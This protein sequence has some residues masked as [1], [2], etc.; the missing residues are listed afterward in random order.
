MNEINDIKI[1][2]LANPRLTETQQAAL[3]F[4][5]TLELEFAEA[6]ILGKARQLTGLSDFGADD[7]RERL[8]VLLQ[9]W[10]NDAGLTGL[11]RL[12]L[13][14]KLVQHA[15]SRLLIE[16]TLKRHPEILDIEIKAPIIVAG[17]PRSG[18]TH[19][20][21][22][23]AA[24][25][26]LRSL[27]LWEAYEPLPRPGESLLPHGRDPRWQRCEDSWQ[28]MQA[29]SP[30]L[31]AMHPMNPDHIHE[32]LELMGPNFA[33]YNYEWLTPSPQWRDHYFSHDQTPHYQYMKNVLKILQWRAGPQRWVLK[34]PQHMEQLTVLHKLF[35][36]ATIAITHRDPVAV[37]QS[38]ITM[39]GYGQRMNRKRVDLPGLLEY[40]SD[41][42][43]HLLRA[44]VR[45]RDTLPTAQA[46]DVP[47]K[48]FM[49]DDIAVVEQIYQRAGMPFEERARGELNAFMQAHPRGK[50]GR[51]VYDLEGDFGISPTT[52]R[53]RFEFYFER[54]PSAG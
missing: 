46:I 23:M 20:L 25:S 18:T 24:D 48:T 6:D 31:A 22:L 33:S 4:C 45:D 53:E 14:N 42:I 21:N 51:I 7:F 11:G 38:A 30:Y 1:T 9:E 47:F 52:L 40:W 19:L 34:C 41:R 27:P 16:D 5:E 12:T 13:H 2:D 32:E 36:D 15:S 3:D 43:E 10:T 17:L 29:N 37:I 54:F 35:P 49:A 28:A 44:C 39:L 26:R 50:E 8:A